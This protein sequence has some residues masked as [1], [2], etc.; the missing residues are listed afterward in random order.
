MEMTRLL[1]ADRLIPGR[2]TPERGASK[3]LRSVVALPQYPDS[4]GETEQE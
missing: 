2:F 3:Q 4:S 1:T